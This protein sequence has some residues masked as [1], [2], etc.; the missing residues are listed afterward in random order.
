MEVKSTQGLG[1]GEKVE[2]KMDMSSSQKV[3]PKEVDPK[4]IAAAK[5]K[6]KK[7]EDAE[8]KKWIPA[9]EWVDAALDNK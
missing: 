7:A 4:S 3:V 5:E 2:W 8:V 6:F 1:T 9:D